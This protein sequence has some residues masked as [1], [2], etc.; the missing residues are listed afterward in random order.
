MRIVQ[1]PLL[2]CNPPDIGIASD[3]DWVSVLPVYSG[4]WRVAYVRPSEGGN[5]SY[6]DGLQYPRTKPFWI[7]AKFTGTIF[8][9][10]GVKISSKVD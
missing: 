5:E 2:A 1:P 9:P 8:F 10:G 7:G 4:R 6:G 3:D